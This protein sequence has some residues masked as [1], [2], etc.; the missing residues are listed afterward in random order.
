MGSL[1]VP[2]TP[3]QAKLLSKWD[4]IILDPLQRGVVE[5]ISTREERHVI[6]RFDVNMIVPERDP[7]ALAVEKA[8]TR[9]FRTFKE[10]AFTGILIVG[11]EER[12]PSGLF[13]SWIDFLNSIGLNVY[14]EAS[15]PGFLKD[16]KLLQSDAVAGLVLRNACILPDGRRRDYFGLAEL[17]E[18]L[19][20]FVS[21]SCMRTDFAVMAW[22]TVDNKSFISN[23]ILKRTMQYCNFY[24]IL[25]YIGSDSAL[26]DATVDRPEIEPLGAF[27]WLKEDRMMKIHEVWKSNTHVLSSPGNVNVWQT[28]GDIFPSIAPAFLTDD[29]LN[30]TTDSKPS[31]FVIDDP[32]E[33]TFQFRRPENPLSVS[34]EGQDYTSLGCFPL[35]LDATPLAFAEVLRGQQRLKELSLLHPMPPAKLQDVGLILRQFHQ[36]FQKSASD[37]SE[38]PSISSAIRELAALATNSLLKVNLGLDSGF[39]KAHG[40][41]F[42]AVYESHPDGLEIF[43]SKKTPGLIHTILHTFLSSRGYT[44]DECFTAENAF[45][46][47]SGDA[48]EE[49]GLSPRMA[50]DIKGLTPEE[51]LLFLQHL[52]FSDAEDMV[53]AKIRA[54]CRF[55]LIQQPSMAQMK[56]SNTVGYLEGKVSASELIRSRLAWYDEQKCPHPEHFKTV[57]LFVEVDEKLESFLRGRDEKLLKRLTDVLEVVIVKDKVDVRA[58]VFALALF[59]AIRKNSLDEVFTEVVDRNPLFNDQSDQAAAFAES[60]ALGSRCEAYFDVLPSTFG[61]LLSDRYRA[62]Y[63]H[64]QPPDWTNGAPALATSYAGA[65]IDVN[66]DDKVKPLPGYQRF[67][68][69]SVFA[70][71]ALVDIILL[72][73]TGRGLYLSA[74]MTFDEQQAATTALMI[75]LLLSGAIGTWISC[76]GNYYLISMAFSALQ[77]FVLTRLFGGMAFTVAGGILGFVVYAS[78]KGPYNGLIFLLYLFAMTAYLTLFATIACFQFPGSTFLSGRKIILGCIPF[79]FVSPVVT[80]W[81][82]HD[83][84]IYISVMYIFI[85]FLVFGLRSISSKWILWYQDLRKTDDAEIKNWFTSIKAGGSEKAFAGLSDPA[86]LKKAREALLADVKSLGGYF[87]KAKDDQLAFELARDFEATNFL[88]DWYCRYSDTPKPI[89]Y[90]SSWNIQVRVALDTLCNAQKGI[91]LH[92]AF[93][94]WRQAG[95]EIG[96][97]ILYFLVALLDKWLQMLCGNRLI[98][99]ASALSDE[100]RM[101]VGFALAYYLIGAVLID[102]KAQHLHT[103]AS[104]L[105]PSGLKDAAEIRSHQKREVRDKRILYWTTLA[106]FLLW[107]VWSLAFTASLLWVFQSSLEAT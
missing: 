63:D 99:L 60:F 102:T 56:E 37:W 49:A 107:H 68:F 76:G 42:W 10:T 9:L 43:V 61:K 38:G 20:A 97:G 25:P 27:E 45:S 104:K 14:L 94:H 47:W 46:E 36:S 53:L 33:W 98:G 103:L 100:F 2:P 32:P 57:E 59:C 90:S 48:V 96:C 84:A 8:T 29:V 50:E 80:M 89:P 83:S 4:L 13:K 52:T 85:G 17:Q 24:S 66:P 41:R 67:G 62:Y 77:S 82:G 54:F 12:L 74:F 15:S 86:I 65:Q 51:S 73:T 19:K 35:G 106:K 39:H 81:S 23:A 18:T 88:L 28:I 22:E 40:I 64:H 91:R 58:D 21:E 105:I 87:A 79:L 3:E 95:D 93:I 72:T 16:P 7:P 69:L 11:W 78:A 70:I 75:S 30:K 92:S 6:G 31:P 101:S 71:P 5:A 34:R 1:N 55:Q 44:R 26:V